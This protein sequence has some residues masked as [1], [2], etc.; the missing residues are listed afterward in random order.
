MLSEAVG[1]LAVVFSCT[2]LIVP[3][4]LCVRKK[5]PSFLEK[6]TK[7]GTPKKASQEGAQAPKISVVSVLEKTPEIEKTPQVKTSKRSTD[8][9]EPRKEHSEAKKEK[10]RT[11]SPNE[12]A[13]TAKEK[14]GSLRQSQKPLLDHLNSNMSKPT[15]SSY[16][17]SPGHSGSTQ[18]FAVNEQFEFLKDMLQGQP[19][20]KAPQKTVVSATPPDIFGNDKKAIPEEEKKKEQSNLKNEAIESESRKPKV[21]PKSAK[22][23]KIAKGET[24]NKSDYPTMDDVV[25]DWDSTQLPMKRKPK[26]EQQNKKRNEETNDEVA[27]KSRMDWLAYERN[28]QGDQVPTYKLSADAQSPVAQ[29]TQED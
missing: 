12:K 6:V 16:V 15:K 24:R 2:V 5:T 14:S 8:K 10:E 13:K 3:I 9:L 28:T 22:E 25:S 23:E 29:P 20:P 18:K 17:K 27:Y 26:D 7:A 21:L 4:I 1:C 19:K 11:E